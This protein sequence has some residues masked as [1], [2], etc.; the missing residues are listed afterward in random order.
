ME[1]GAFPETFDK[2]DRRK[3]SRFE[4]KE[5]DEKFTNELNQELQ[6]FF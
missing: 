2:K 1:E 3:L 4:R 5:K 6:E